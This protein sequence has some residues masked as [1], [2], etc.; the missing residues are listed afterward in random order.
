MIPNGPGILVSVDYFG[1]LPLTL[2]GNAY[3]LIF[4]DRFSRRADMYATTETQ[5]TASGTVDILVDRYITL[6]GCP[7]TLLFDNGFQV[8]SKL[9]LALYYRLGINKTATSSYHSFTNGGVERV[10]HTM[11]HMLAMV[12]DE[13]QTDWDIQLSHV[14][15]AYNNSVSAATGLASNEMH[16]GRL[17]RLPLTVFDFPNI[18]EHQSLNRDQVAFIDLVTARQQR[19]FC[20]VREIHAI[21]VSRLDRRNAPLMN[22][23]RLLPPF[24]VKGWVW[25]Y[26]SAATIRQGASEGTDAIVLKAK[27]SFNWIGPF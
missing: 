11:A 21:Y 6:W 4:T 3:I 13:Q 26:N 25:I 12:G 20:A 14:E 10:N 16:M 15:S 5:F 1:P 2:R 18:G 27:L 7:V 23:L 17:P 9:S 24:F 22:T 19:A 8:C